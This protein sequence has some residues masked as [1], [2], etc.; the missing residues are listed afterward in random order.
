MN[1]LKLLSLLLDYP[2]DE[3]RQWLATDARRPLELVRRID[4][5]R[6]LTDDERAAVA[7]FIEQAHDADFTEFQQAYVQT[8]DMAPEHSLHLTHH[9]FGDDRGRGPA[10]IDLA[11]YYKSYGLQGIDG[12]LPDYLPLMLEFASRLDPGE[13]RV[14]LGDAGKVIGVLAD[15]LDRAGSPYAPL[16]RIVRSYATLA[17]LAA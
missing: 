2:D 14:F 7:A 15:N 8:F 10:L 13:A 5:E 4:R 9:I 16:L 11:E 1:A 12:E 6:L 3:L 17:K